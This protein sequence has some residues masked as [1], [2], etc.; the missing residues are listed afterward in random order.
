MQRGILSKRDLL[1]CEI[2]KKCWCTTNQVMELFRVTDRR[3]LADKLILIGNCF[4][5]AESEDKGRDRK[6]KIMTDEDYK[7]YLKSLIN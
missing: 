7:F 2:L 1:A 4:P 3:K 6:Y 5:L